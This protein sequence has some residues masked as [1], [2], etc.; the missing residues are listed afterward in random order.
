MQDGKVLL[1]TAVPAAPPRARRNPWALPGRLALLALALLPLALG[2]DFTLHLAI[3]I[4]I[5]VVLVSGLS[6]LAR[7]GQVSLCHGAFAGIGAYVSVLVVMG[8]GQPFVLGALAAILAAGLFA[9]LLGTIMLRLTGVYF[10][11]LTFA[12]GEFVRLV[13]LEGDSVTGGANGITGVPPAALLGHV[14]DNKTA[15]YLLALACAAGVTWLL[16]AL[17]RSPAGHAID[18][19]GENAQ[20]AEATGISVRGTQRYAFTLG[21]ALA[22]LGGALTAHY[23][24]YVSPESFSMHLSLALIIMMV[25]G[26]RR[27]LFGPL[28]G[29]LIMTPLP[30]LFRGAVETQ[31]IFYGAALILMLR[32]LPQGLASLFRARRAH[33]E[34]NRGDKA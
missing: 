16:H 15:F 23:L 33:E 20:L 31:N 1:S 9:Y 11:L 6:L 29:A 13:L 10:V 32:F 17:Y 30:E 2:R 27:Y 18:A 14:L 4:C 24:R 12:F 34:K 8:L 22:G 3:Q 19:V 21:S 26:G 5:N 7:A 28:I 25:V